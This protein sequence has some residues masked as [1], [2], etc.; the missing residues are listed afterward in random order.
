LNFAPGHWRA[1]AEPLANAFAALTP[2]AVRLGYP[3]T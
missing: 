3:E 1:Y 2:V